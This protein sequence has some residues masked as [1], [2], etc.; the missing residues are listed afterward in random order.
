MIELSTKEA[1]RDPTLVLT[2]NRLPHPWSAFRWLK[3][4]LLTQFFASESQMLPKL[5]II[6]AALNTRFIDAA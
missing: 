2:G 4:G 6:P 3:N 1:D 5:H